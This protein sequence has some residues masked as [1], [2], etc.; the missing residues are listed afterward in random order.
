MHHVSERPGSASP[1]A[2]TAPDS[3]A[4]QLKLLPAILDAVAELRQILAG[5]H[6]SHLTVE[7]VAAEVGMAPYTIRTWIKEGRLAAVRVSGTGPKGRL[8]IPRDELAKLVAA[9]GA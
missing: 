5:R 6:K 9:G 1:S 7:E 3:I 8:L 2:E 4:L